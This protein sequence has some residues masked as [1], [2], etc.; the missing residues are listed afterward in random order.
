MEMKN[1]DGDS[2]SSNE[3]TV[4]SSFD[5]E[6]QSSCDEN[7]N[8][9]I[10]HKYHDLDHNQDST[11][12]LSC[13]ESCNTIENDRGSLKSKKGTV[14]FNIVEIRRYHTRGGDHPDCTSG[15]PITYGWQYRDSPNDPISVEKYE[16]ERG[17]RRTKDELRLTAFERRH[18]LNKNGYDRNMCD[19]WELKAFLSRRQRQRT[20]RQMRFYS[21][22]RR[23]VNDIVLMFSFG[24]NH[25]SKESLTLLRTTNSISR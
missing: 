14:R 7:Y 11:E 13:E 1:L 23:V 15:P 9:T 2:C 4:I 16:Q 20:A 3:T 18:L 25:K 12:E 10:A 17:E 5:H 19:A 6:E 8:T 22:V 24:D 21:Q